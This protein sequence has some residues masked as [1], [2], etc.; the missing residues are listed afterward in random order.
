VEKLGLKIADEKAVQPR[1][2]L[3]LWVT[4]SD[5]NIETGPRAGQSKERFTV[6]VVSE[7]ELLAEIAKEEESLHIKLEESVNRL[8]DAKVKLTK[9]TEELP[10]LK[11]DEFSPLA[12]RSEEIGEAIVKSWDS[13][14]EI[15]ADYKRILKE[16]RA[17]R[18]QPGMINK[19]NDKICEPLDGAI[20][21]EFVQADDGLHELQKKL[22]T[23]SRD[24]K[25]A[26]TAGQQLD[27]LIRR[28]SGVLEAMADVTTINRIIEMLVKIEKG[29]REE[30]E[31]LQK[32][33]RQ[34]QEE[35]LENLSDPKK[36]EK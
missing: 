10:E 32:L 31:R 8:K 2:R 1:Y 36:P 25:T 22:E 20:N 3:R 19:V 27:Q 11:P 28:L 26:E 15:F 34:K 16:L 12:R 24:L 13:V 18:V 14:R 30:Y 5:N 17:N 35:V 6:L 21:V 23:K 33:L 29:E 7:H 4:A 9:I